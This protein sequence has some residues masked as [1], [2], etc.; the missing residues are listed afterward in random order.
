MEFN[1]VIEVGRLYTPDDLRLLLLI[2]AENERLK[3]ELEIAKGI[4]KTPW[5]RRNARDHFIKL[6]KP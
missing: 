2:Q 6:S 5:M 3:E 4:I 1:H